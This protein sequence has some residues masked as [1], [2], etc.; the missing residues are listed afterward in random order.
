M[1]DENSDLYYDQTPLREY[2]KDAQASSEEE[3][4][5]AS[6][7][8]LLKAERES[9]P[10]PP[11]H[12]SPHLRRIP[13]MPHTP[14]QSHSVSFSPR[15]HPSQFTPGPGG[16][17]QSLPVTPQHQQQF[18]NG[19]SGMGMGGAGIG[20]GSPMGGAGLGMHM[21]GM[22]M[23]GMNMAGMSM[24]MASPEMRRMAAARNGF[25]GMH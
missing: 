5:V 10:P 18:F 19:H 17:S 16:F 11:V 3:K 1:V 24:S 22:S 13:Q 23:G 8:D 21:D 15:H 7:S 9:M 6:T 25:S 20:I 12:D 2:E 4:A 14:Q